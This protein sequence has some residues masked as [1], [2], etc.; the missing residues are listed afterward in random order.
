MSNEKLFECFKKGVGRF[1]VIVLEII[2]FVG[3]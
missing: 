2:L 1:R 3:W